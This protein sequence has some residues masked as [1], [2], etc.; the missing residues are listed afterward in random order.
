MNDIEV[1]DM[2]MGA[3]ILVCVQFTMVSLIINIEANDE[4]FKII[5]ATSYLIIIPR[6]I[7]AIMMHLT[8]EPDIRSGISLMKYSVNN[9]HCFKGVTKPD[10]SHNYSKV[11]APFMLGFL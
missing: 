11:I 8:V 3:I 5:P 2:Y 9:P 1:S 7:S 10:G 6:F 4:S